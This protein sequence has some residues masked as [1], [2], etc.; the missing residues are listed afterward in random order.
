MLNKLRRLLRKL[1]LEERAQAAIEMLLIFPT[2]FLVIG[3]IIDFGVVMY[4]YV[5]ITNAVREGARYAAVNCSGGSCTTAL[6]C[7]RTINSSSGLLDTSHASAKVRWLDRTANSQVYNRGDSAVVRI[8][9]P[10]N[11][12]FVPGVT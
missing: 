1:G 8:V 9:H 3:L 6:V 12:I 2:F 4:Q 10:Y 11:L 7:T 5:T